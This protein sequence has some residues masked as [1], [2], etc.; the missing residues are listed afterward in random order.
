[1][2]WKLLNFQGQAIQLKKKGNYELSQIEDAKKI[3][4]SFDMPV[5]ANSA[6]IINIKN[7][8][9][10]GAWVALLVKHPTLDLG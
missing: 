9:Y 2:F 4:V 7:I 5:N 6:K 1:M 8:D 3:P 10:R